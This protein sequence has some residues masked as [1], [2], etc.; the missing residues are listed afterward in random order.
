[1]EPAP[2]LGMTG[3]R[4]HARPP[5]PGTANVNVVGESGRTRRRAGAWARRPPT[6]VGYG[7]RPTVALL[8]PPERRPASGYDGFS[9]GSYE[10]APWPGLTRC[11]L[12][13]GPC[14]RA[15]RMGG[16]MTMTALSDAELLAAAR[17]SDEGA[18]TELYVRH[19]AAAQRLA[20]GYRR[21]G[22][23]DDLVN[24]A[25]ERVLAALRRGSAHRLVPGLPVRHA[26]TPRDGAGQAR[27]RRVP[28]RGARAG[29]RRGRR[30]RARRG[31]ARHHR[32]G[33]RVAARAV[34]DGA[35]ADR[36]RGQAAQGLR[37]NDGHD[38]QRRRRPRLPCPRAAAAGVP[39]GAPAAGGPRRLRATSLAAGRLRARWP[40]PP[41]GALD[42]GAP[43]PVRVVLDARRRAERRQPHAGAHGGADLPDRLR[44]AAGRRPDLGRLRGGRGRGFTEAAASVAS[45][46]SGAGSSAGVTG[47]GA[48]GAAGPGS[49]V[50][51]GLFS[52][53]LD[54]GRRVGAMAAALAAAA[55]VVVALSV[56]LLP[57]DGGP[58]GG[59]AEVD[60][61]TDGG[62]QSDD[63]A[64]SR[65]PTSTTTT[66]TVAAAPTTTAP[67]AAGHHH[68]GTE[69]A[70]R[71]HRRRRARAPAVAR[72]RRPRRPA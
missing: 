7:A 24:G 26:A 31:R 48:A 41:A 30:S 27:R 16:V 5:G 69:G 65:R 64:P 20:Q 14:G 11:R 37:R 47:S 45:G 21:L 1:M 17:G 63:E 50:A 44:R 67:G 46:A 36:G 18:F 62:P 23:P 28:R 4:R 40:E 51:G 32:P 15:T 70:L 56:T 19:H 59:G 52:G 12:P 60:L 39:A 10:I 54:G 43:G 33:L 3:G 38:A 34:A 42:Q 57:H 35:V 71:R 6:G 22:D 8:M 61:Q 29:G 25:F 55:A 9:T 53:G 72:R 13:G 66:T 2:G 49:S 58:S 68:D